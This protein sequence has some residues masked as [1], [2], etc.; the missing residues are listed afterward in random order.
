M[1]TEL[2]RQVNLL[3]M[4]NTFDPSIKLPVTYNKE[5]T[6]KRMYDIAYD[7]S[8]G[9]KLDYNAT[10]QS[11]VDELPGNPK[12]QANRDTIAAGL[13]SLGRPTQFHQTLNLNWQIPLNKLPFMDFTSTS[14]RYTANY[15]WTSNSTAA[16]NPDSKS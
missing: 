12:T 2:R 3:Q 4:R 9:I 15:D 14:L 10:A 1:R 5:L 8:K 16:L 11:R 6:T 7:L 13:A